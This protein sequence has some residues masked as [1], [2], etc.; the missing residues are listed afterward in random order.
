ML[1]LVLPDS[2]P[3]YSLPLYVPSSPGSFWV[4]QKRFSQTPASTWCTLATSRT[5]RLSASPCTLSAPYC[6]NFLGFAKEIFTDAGK[7]VV[8]FGYQPDTA[9]AMAEKTLA[10]RSGQADVRVTP[11]AQLR[12]E[13]AVIPS[14]TGNQLVVSQPLPLDER[15]I[16]LAAA[17]SGGGLWP[18][19]WST[20]GT[21]VRACFSSMRHVAAVLGGSLT[22]PSSGVGIVLNCVGAIVLCVLSAVLCCS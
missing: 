5:N 6:R 18:V 2:S 21:E 9:A 4:L 15:M 1:N 17:I 20:V 7:Y 16:A 3:T 22:H 10:I 11:L 13:V 14:V 12:T 19:P 8:H